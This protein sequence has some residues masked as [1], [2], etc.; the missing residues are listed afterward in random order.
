MI[1]VAACALALTAIVYGASAQDRGPR[2]ACTDDAA[3][4]CPNVQPGEGRVIACLVKD[5]S[6]L[7]AACVQLLTSMGTLK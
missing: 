2:N 4:L 3:K 6:K 5:K 1:R 7:T